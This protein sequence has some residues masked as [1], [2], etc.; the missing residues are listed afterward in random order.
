MSIFKP[1]LKAKSRLRVRVR[2]R[3][4]S[5]NKRSRRPRRQR[6]R[7]RIRQRILDVESCDQRRL[8]KYEPF[9]AIKAKTRFTVIA[10]TIDSGRFEI[11]KLVKSTNGKISPTSLKFVSNL[12]RR[13]LKQIKKLARSRSVKRNVK[14]RSLPKSGDL[15]GLTEDYVCFSSRPCGPN[16]NDKCDTFSPPPAFQNKDDFI[17]V[18]VVNDPWEDLQPATSD[19]DEI[20]PDTLGQCVLSDMD[21]LIVLKTSNVTIKQWNKLKTMVKALWFLLSGQDSNVHNSQSKVALLLGEC[22]VKLS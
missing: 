15:P 19:L 20:Q 13:K 9:L 21:V 2:G 8:W 12:I 11:G 22:S 5:S 18:S 10:F 1:F 7:Q 17:G 14:L 6:R 3:R 4:S 16:C